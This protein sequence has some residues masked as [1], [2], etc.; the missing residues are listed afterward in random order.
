M[1]HER[2]RLSGFFVFFVAIPMVCGCNER[3]VIDTIFRN[4]SKTVRPVLEQNITLHVEYE[5]R[6]YSIISVDEP[7]EFVTFLLWTTRTWK[8]QYL[9]WNPKDFDGCTTVKVTVDHIW[10]PDIYFL[11]TLDTQSISLT[12][13][14]Y[15]DLSYDGEIRQYRK[16]KAQLSCNMAIGDFPFDTQTCPIIVGLWTYNYSELILHLR[17]P[18]VGLA[19]YN[20]DPDYAPIMANNSEFETVSFTG[21]EVKSTVGPFTYSELHY[22]IGLK[23]RPAYYIYVI[24]IPS[25]LLTSLCIIGIFTPNSNINERNERVTL[26]LTTLLSMAV[27]LNI[28]ADQMPKGSEGLPLLGI[29]VLYE[30]GVLSAIVPQ[31]PTMDYKRGS[32]DGSINHVIDRNVERQTAVVLSISSMVQNAIESMKKRLHE[33]EEKEKRELIWENVFD[34]L[35]SVLLV[36]LLLL[37]TLISYF[38]LR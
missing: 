34:S 37:N 15:V 33:D 16:F 11:N 28:V 23:R 38:L 5:L 7:D 26:G 13:N 18:I 29:F 9:T 30:I 3:K 32:P 6:V 14:D 12:G 25:Y 21:V 4:Y 8:D 2:Y 22:S 31:N 20:G 35:D 1:F 24:L 36:L 19:S 17:Y 10:L 27:I